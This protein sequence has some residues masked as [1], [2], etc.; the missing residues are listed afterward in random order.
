[1]KINELLANM[2]RANFD[3]A[4]ELQVKTYLPIEEKKLIAQGIIYECTEEVDGMVKLDSVQQYLSYVKYMI[5]R[6]T[7]LE[8]TDAD[9]DTLNTTMHG[10]S[11]LFNAIF[12]Y[13]ES[14]A[15]E[16]T[17]ILGLM[18]GDYLKQND[19]TAQLGTFL[20]D[21]N[22]IVSKLSEILQEKISNVDLASIL[23]ENVDL[24]K[25]GEFLNNNF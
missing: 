24:Q 3:M 11:T 9:Y 20:N 8:Y 18:V 21:I 6:H 19:M 5:I 17:R 1:M 4:K 13:F 25:L 2:H 23:P 14:D 7:N 15:K 10:E 16:C 12:A 22:A